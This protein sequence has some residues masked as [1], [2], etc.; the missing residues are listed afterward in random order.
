[1]FSRVAVIPFKKITK[2]QTLKN[3]LDLQSN[4]KEVLQF[5][6]KSAGVILQLGASF[7]NMREDEPFQEMLLAVEEDDAGLYMRTQCNH[8]LVLFSTGKVS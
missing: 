4:L 1:M 6:I 8:A 7:G 5:I 2:K 3:C